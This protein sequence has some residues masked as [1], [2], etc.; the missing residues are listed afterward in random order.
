[1]RHAFK[2][3]IIALLPVACVLGVYL[4][5]CSKSKCSG[6]NCLYGGSCSNG[7]CIC[8][9]GTGGSDCST[10]YRNLYAGY[11]YMGSGTNND[12]P[13]RSL[14]NYMITVN[15]FND[16][17]YDSMEINAQY[18]NTSGNYVTHFQANIALTASTNS[19]S[20]FAITPTVNE[21]GFRI[22]G[23]GTL[24]AHTATLTI[25]E[26]DTATKGYIQPTLVYTF[27]SLTKQ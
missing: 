3:F 24:A 6:V 15:T 21:Q 11:S 5:S 16:A 1:M 20:S 23:T 25:T 4:S 12:N 27:S 17:H 7:S 18:L 8:P 10:I 13:P 19:S 9:A 14:Q 22:S 26:A 2:Y